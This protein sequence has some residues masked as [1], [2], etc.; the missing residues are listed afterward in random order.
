M[1]TVLIILF[2]FWAIVGGVFGLSL[3]YDQVLP[4]S[5]LFKNTCGLIICGPLW[6][7]GRVGIHVYRVLV[8]WLYTEVNSSEAKR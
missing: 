5:S 4:H 3:Y 2:I 1:I 7:I 8:I 6:W